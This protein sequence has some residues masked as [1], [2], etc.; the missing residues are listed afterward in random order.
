MAIFNRSNSA[1]HFGLELDGNF[2]GWVASADGGM[3]VAE[4][5]TEKL[6]TDQ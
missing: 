2:A 1:G 3:G 5:I 4:V 6:G